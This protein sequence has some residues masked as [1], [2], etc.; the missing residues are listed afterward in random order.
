MGAGPR[1]AENLKFIAGMPPAWQILAERYGS[2]YQLLQQLGITTDELMVISNDESKMSRPLQL[3]L[4]RVANEV[5]ITHW[6]WHSP[7]PKSRK[8]WEE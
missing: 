2:A 6:G 8:W 5:G 1:K 3:L 4:I 7:I